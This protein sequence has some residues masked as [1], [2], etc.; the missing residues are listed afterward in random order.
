[1]IPTDAADLAAAIAE[2]EAA[3]PGWWWSVC[4]CSVSRD[5]S[6]APDAAGPDA[7]LLRLKQFDDGFHC[8][9]RAGTLASSLRDVM[10]KGLHA[11]TRAALGE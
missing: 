3:L 9:D 1:M 7:R 2:F 4:T 5:A 11:K 6:C 10:R 8:D